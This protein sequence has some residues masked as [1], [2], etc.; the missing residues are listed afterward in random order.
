VGGLDLGSTCGGSQCGQCLESE[1]ERSPGTEWSNTDWLSLGSPVKC[2]LSQMSIMSS[3]SCLEF[4][5]ESYL[6]T[7]IN[8][9]VVVIVVHFQN[10]TTEA[11]MQHIWCKIRDG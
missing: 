5:G 8:L 4:A 10:Q 2:T 11:G 3:S 7:T 9:P 1:S 6:H